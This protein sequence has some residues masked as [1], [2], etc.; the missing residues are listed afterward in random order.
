MGTQA[1]LIGAVILFASDTKEDVAREVER[2]V[3]TIQ[4]AFNR[5]D[6][7]TLRGLMAEDLVTVLPYARFSNAADLLKVLSA[8]KYSDYKIE[9]LRVKALTGD[10][11]LVTYQATIK[12]TYR[13]KD[14]PS[15]VWV[16]EVW[17]KRDGKWL[18]ASYQE[19]PVANNA[20]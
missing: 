10:V 8:W 1:L 5:G 11:A 20:K 13:G 2:A 17:V 16:A 14:V 9:G 4:A 6:A 7:A 3:Q 18:Q 15:P 19:T 12:G